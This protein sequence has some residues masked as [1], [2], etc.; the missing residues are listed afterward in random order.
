MPCRVTSAVRSGAGL[1]TIPVTAGKTGTRNFG[2]ASLDAV[3]AKCDRSATGVAGRTW[4][5]PR[6]RFGFVKKP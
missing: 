4:E 2:A 3:D 5:E 6:W 1:T